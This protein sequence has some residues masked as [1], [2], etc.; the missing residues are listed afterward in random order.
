V[1]D[2]VYMTQP[3]G[4]N[5]VKTYTWQQTA[6]QA[7]R[8]AAYLRALPLEPGSNIAILSKNCAHFVLADLAIWMAGHVSVAL[9]PTLNAETVRQI[10]EHSEAKLLFVGKLIRNK[11]V[12]LLVA[13]WPAIMEANP[14]ARLLLAGF[15]DLRDELEAQIRDLGEEV[16]SSISVSGRLEHSEVA[17]VMPAAR[18]L[19][20]PSVFP[21]AFGMVAVEAASCGTFPV[22]A[23]HS[24][25]LEVS[26]QL[27]ATLPSAS[28]ELVSFPV[29]VG[30]VETIAARLDALLA[31]PEEQ[32]ER[33]RAA[34]V[35]TARR[36]WSWEGVARGVLAASA[37]ELSSLPLP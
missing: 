24:G 11:G 35:E 5:A 28:A 2:R 13:A 25:M 10:M 27:A 4:G 32:R 26:R 18:T 12:D 30:A 16:G 34:L 6:D 36:V 20:M 37:G 1:P 3:L 15:G 23:G 14:G 19:V 17:E 22:S 33:S 29:Q 8:M 7:R 9:Y 31:L 21:E